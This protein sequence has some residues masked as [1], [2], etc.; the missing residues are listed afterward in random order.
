MGCPGFSSIVS[1]RHNIEKRPSVAYHGFPVVPGNCAFVLPRC[2]PRDK[3]ARWDMGASRLTKRTVDALKAT[4]AEYVKWDVDIPGF[5]VRV[6]SS[7][8]KTYIVQYRAG[9]G[10]KAP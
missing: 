2:Y 7:G 4:G 1:N 8:A 6:R 10:R 3:G 9:A 5:G